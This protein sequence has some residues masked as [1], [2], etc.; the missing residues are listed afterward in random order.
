MN[1][2]KRNI[3]TFTVILIAAICFIA[4]PTFLAKKGIKKRLIAAGK[5]HQV[6]HR[7]EGQATIYQLLSGDRVLELT[8]F[9]TGQGQNL[10]LLLISAPDA[11]ENETVEKSIIYSLGELQSAASHQQFTIPAHFDL[12][13]VG[14]VT[15][16]STKYRVNF[17]TAP[18]TQQ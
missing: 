18:L 16:W 13:K 4:G 8:D 1:R 5:F 17:T 14:A 6:A 12:R 2:R 9:Y 11:L 3:T 15:V 7:G 10:E